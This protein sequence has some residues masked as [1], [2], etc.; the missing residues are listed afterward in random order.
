MNILR[1]KR[2]F[3]MKQKEFFKVFKVLSFGEKINSSRQKL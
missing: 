3:S 2:A 1:M